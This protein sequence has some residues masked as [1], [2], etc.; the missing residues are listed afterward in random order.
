MP[1]GVALPRLDLASARTRRAMRGGRLTLR[2]TGFS[3]GGILFGSVT[4]HPSH[5]TAP[6]HGSPGI[7]EMSS[8]MTRSKAASPDQ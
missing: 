8:L 3:T 6:A 4:A 5:R 1:P 7:R 2:R